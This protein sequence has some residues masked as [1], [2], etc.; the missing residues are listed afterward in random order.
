MQLISQRVITRFCRS[1]YVNI[2]SWASG[3][4]KGHGRM[5][6]EMCCCF[7]CLQPLQGALHLVGLQERGLHR[8]QV[9]DQSNTR[10]CVLDPAASL[11]NER[12]EVFFFKKSF[13]F[14]TWQKQIKML[15]LQMKP[16]E[17]MSRAMTNIQASK[18]GMVYLSSNLFNFLR[19][20]WAWSMNL[21]LQLIMMEIDFFCLY[22]MTTFCGDS[23]L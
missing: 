16:D 15:S 12:E 18:N 14:W 22:F 21:P 7:P 17:S 2:T 4:E 10:H 8:G 9:P 13:A 23:K 11:L 20:D 3:S 1:Q 19:R 5:K 6:I